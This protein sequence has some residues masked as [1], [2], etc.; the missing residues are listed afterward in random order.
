[1]EFV[2]NH[3]CRP[4]GGHNANRIRQ[5]AHASCKRLITLF[6]KSRFAITALQPVRRPSTVG[7]LGWRLGEEIVLR[8]CGSG[9]SCVQL[10]LNGREWCYKRLWHNPRFRSRNLTSALE[11]E[12]ERENGKNDHLAGDMWCFLL[13]YFKLRF[14]YSML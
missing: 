8:N 7:P 14:C 6:E 9:K 13:C 12:T 3:K 10:H 5:N 11:S 2:Y 1:V 4:A